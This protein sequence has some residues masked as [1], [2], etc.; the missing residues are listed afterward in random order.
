MRVLCLSLLSLSD[1]YCSRSFVV[2]VGAPTSNAR[3]GK[4][5]TIEQ[6]V[7]TLAH[8][9]LTSTLLVP[10]F[11][12]RPSSSSRSQ[13]RRSARYRPVFRDALVFSSPF[14]S[15]PSTLP[16]ASS[17]KLPSSTRHHAHAVSRRRSTMR[18]QE[19]SSAPLLGQD[20]RRRR[21]PVDLTR[22]RTSKTRSWRR[23]R[24]VKP[25]FSAPSRLKT[26]AI[27]IPA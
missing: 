12:P 8:C 24:A 21:H 6:L 13:G 25:F 3:D 11:G 22:L 23:G 4:G 7:I 16:A 20:V 14:H 18:V 1:G 27:T 17:S 9:S 2:R 26:H 5:T 10:S 15:S 19:T